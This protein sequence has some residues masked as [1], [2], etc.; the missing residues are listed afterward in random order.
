MSTF[1]SLVTYPS[2]TSRAHLMELDAVRRLLRPYVNG[3]SRRQNSSLVTSVRPS[4]AVRRRYGFSDAV[5]REVLFLLCGLLQSTDEFLLDCIESSEGESV[6]DLI[7]SYQMRRSIDCRLLSRFIEIS[8]SS[9]EELITAISGKDSEEVRLLRT[10]DAIVRSG[11]FDRS[12]LAELSVP[13]TSERALRCIRLRMRSL[14][15][16]DV[17]SLADRALFRRCGAV[18][19]RFSYAECIDN[20]NSFQKIYAIALFTSN[21]PWE[22]SVIARRVL[23]ATFEKELPAKESEAE[24]ID[25]IQRMVDGQNA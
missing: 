25:A 19:H 10:A 23:D 6:D 4:D 16:A 22:W 14:A 9:V 24:R 3:S 12:T 17:L 1:T 7:A 21:D 5:F 11:Y 2:L 18:L 20:G 13:V 8:P 15:K